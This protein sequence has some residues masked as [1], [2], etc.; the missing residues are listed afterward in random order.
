MTEKQVVLKEFR[1]FPLRLFSECE[2]K[3]LESSRRLMVCLRT[4]RHSLISQIPSAMRFFLVLAVGLT[5][6]LSEA[7][8]LPISGGRTGHQLF[9]SSNHRVSNLRLRPSHA[10]P[11]LFGFPVSLMKNNKA[12][13]VPACL[14]ASMSA[15][16]STESQSLSRLVGLRGRRYILV[17]GK[18]GVGKTST[19]FVAFSNMVAMHMRTHTMIALEF[20]P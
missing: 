14:A 8:L 2:D 10:N 1:D 20:F 3:V 18:G 11:S 9:T 17:G 16:S 7:Y 19:R 15:K 4:H 12:Q 6:R 13:R 5:L